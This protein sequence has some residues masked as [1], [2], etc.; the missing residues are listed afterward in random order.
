MVCATLMTEVAA[1]E[2]PE[3]LVGPRTTCARRWRWQRWCRRSNAVAGSAGRAGLGDAAGSAAA[4]QVGRR[5]HEDRPVRELHDVAG[6]I[7]E[8][9]RPQAGAALRAE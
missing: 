4:G 6:N 2:S 3:A 8:Q 7:T 1:A 5:N 9:D